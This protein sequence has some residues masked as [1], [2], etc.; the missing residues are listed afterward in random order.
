MTSSEQCLAHPGHLGET[1]SFS[2]PCVPVHVGVPESRTGWGRGMGCGRVC[3]ESA[4][5]VWGWMKEKR[6]A[7]GN[8]RQEN[9]GWRSLPAIPQ[10]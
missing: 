9:A 10:P 6:E 8:S 2:Y 4:L 3:R 7:Q 1:G 5:S